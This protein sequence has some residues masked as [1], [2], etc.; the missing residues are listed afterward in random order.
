[1]V[2]DILET[3]RTCRYRLIDAI[4]GRT[5]RT[6]EVLVSIAAIIASGSLS[7]VTAATFG[8]FSNAA[9]NPN[10]AITSGLKVLT[11]A[12]NPW[13]AADVGKAIDVAGAGAAGVTLRSRI[14]AYTS[15]GQVTLADAAGT[16]IAPTKTSAGGVA[17]W[18]DDHTATKTLPAD[19]NAA[20]TQ[21]TSDLSMSAVATNATALRSI[22]AHFSEVVN[23][24]DYGAVGDGVT[25]DTL[26]W[27]RAIARVQA[28][29]SYA[30]LYIPPGLYRIRPDLHYSVNYA[31]RAAT[32]LVDVHNVAVIG[33][34]ATVWVDV[35]PTWLIGALTNFA[36]EE[37]PIQFRTSASDGACHDISVVGVR[38]LGT[39]LTG[40]YTADGAA[41]GVIYRGVRRTK[42]IGV[43]C[44]NWSTDGLYFGKSYS[45]TYAG[46]DHQV[47]GCRCASNMRQ[48]LSVVGNDRVSIIGSAFVDTSG[49][50]FGHGI[51]LEPD[52]VTFQSDVTITGCMFKNNQRGAFNCIRTHN[53]TFS[54][55]VLDEQYAGASP[56][57]GA[58]F[59]DG[60]GVSAMRGLRIAGNRITAN[61]SVLYVTGNYIEDVDFV[62]NDCEMVGSVAGSYYIIR[63][64]AGTA[65]YNWRIA[66]NRLDGCGG[67]LLNV[68]DGMWFED[69]VMRIYK[70]GA[71]SAD[72]FSIAVSSPVL[73]Y[74]RGNRITIESDVIHAGTKDCYIVSGVVENNEFTSHAAAILSMQDQAGGRVVRIGLNKFSTYFYFKGLTTTRDVKID[75]PAYQ[76]GNFSPVIEGLTSAG[77]GTY[78]V[79]VGEY[80]RI[81][82]LVHFSINLTWSAHTGT[83]NIRVAGFPFTASNITG[84]SAPFSIQTNNLVVTAGQIRSAA[85]GT[86]DTGFALLREDPAGGAANLVT[87]DTAGTLA[88][89]G[90][91]IAKD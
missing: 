3:P 90:S 39:R 47:I 30:A 26:A 27:A 37:G 86:N 29:G 33:W 48:G 76:R 49:S 46:S 13:T 51:D 88:L 74:F 32:E 19:Q 9:G 15:A 85:A 52:G 64:V 36:N 14:M 35:S 84:M 41:M 67:L 21:E 17:I 71:A 81:G 5:V 70:S 60:G 57:A 63:I 91:F 22:A 75:M 28:I 12:D 89:S 66:R 23:L 45:N 42:T 40:G 38:V 24:K 56:G 31:W 58:I 54:E 78:S 59:I 7:A 43:T 79:Q 44:E 34:G 87:M 6:A 65:N 69:N 62:G 1:M 25:D 8:L 73:H 55:N 10:C 2:R 53:V 77:V 72:V 16:T 11:S 61:K 4:V 50:S 83:G 18:G 82:S 80:V 68:N 20:G